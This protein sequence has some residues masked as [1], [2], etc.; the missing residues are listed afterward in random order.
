MFILTIVILG[1]S[2]FRKRTFLLEA[3]NRVGTWGGPSGGMSLLL[4]LNTVAS[5]V[6]AVGGG[7]ILRAGSGATSCEEPEQGTA[8]VVPA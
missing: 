8:G 6:L 1:V 3:G 5:H 2:C 4:A 7:W